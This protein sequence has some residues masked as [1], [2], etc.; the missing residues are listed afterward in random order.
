MTRMRA[1]LVLSA[2][3]LLA[4]CNQTT[5]PQASAPA[6]GTPAPSQPHVKLPAGAA[7]TAEI[8]RFRSIIDSDLETGNVG[9][10][11]H[12]AMVTELRQPE[13]LCAAGNDG[14]SR[15]ALHTVKARHGY[16]G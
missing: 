9:E 15:A 5:S 16:P 8:E 10:K 11:V 4:G 2:A 6:Q 14:G 3:L 12:A 13:S 7:C 1:F